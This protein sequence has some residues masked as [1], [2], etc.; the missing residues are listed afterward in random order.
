MGVEGALEALLCSLGV[1]HGDPRGAPV[2]SGASLGR[3]LGGPW[4]PSGGAKA[5]LGREIG[6]L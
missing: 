4:G 5:V 1:L 2:E 6:S 3:L